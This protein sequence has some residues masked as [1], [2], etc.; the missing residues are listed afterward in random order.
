MKSHIREIIAPVAEEMHVAV[1]DIVGYQPS[2]SKSAVNARREVIRRM[3]CDHGMTV[4]DVGYE[5]GLD[6]S[7][8]I[9]SARALGIW[10]P[11]SRT[12]HLLGN[13]HANPA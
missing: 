4:T 7:T 12:M 2:K 10:K 11:A 9:Y 5:L 13:R 1:R 8:V 6:H 3:I